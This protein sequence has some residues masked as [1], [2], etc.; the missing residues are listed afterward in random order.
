M[1]RWATTRLLRTHV[2]GGAQKG[3][4]ARRVILEVVAC[5]LGNA[6]IQDLRDLFVVA[7]NEIDVLRLQVPVHDAECMRARESARDVGDDPVSSL[8]FQQSNA[9]EAGAKVFALE[10]LHCNVEDS[11]GL[12]PIE[13]IDHVWS[14]Q[15]RRCLCLSNETLSDLVAA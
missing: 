12:T 14:A 10:V 9:T 8:W 3:T 11:V 1:I 5:V 2:I 15:L 6:E 13:H 4:L 7:L